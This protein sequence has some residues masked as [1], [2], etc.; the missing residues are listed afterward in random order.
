M[1]D[2][3]N[4]PRLLKQLEQVFGEFPDIRRGENKQYDL[5]DAGLGAFAVFFRQNASFLAHQQMLKA[6]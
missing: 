6:S 3:L 4:M 1:D 5:A 2:A